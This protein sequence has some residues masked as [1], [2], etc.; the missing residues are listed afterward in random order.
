MNTNLDLMGVLIT[1]YDPRTSLAREVETEIRNVL[2]KETLNTVIHRSVKLEE[3]AA[4]GQS[5]FTYAPKS[6]AAE[7]YQAAYRELMDRA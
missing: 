5:I 4:R 2:P 3:S 6:K 7:E 1:L